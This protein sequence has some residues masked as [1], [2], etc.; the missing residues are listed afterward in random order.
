MA[1]FDRYTNYKD[2]AGVSGV[3]FGADS[4]VLE[5]ELNEMQEIQKHMMHELVKNIVGSGISDLSKLTYADGKVKIEDG[6]ILTCGGYIIKANNLEYST[7]SDII[8]L[9]VWEDIVSYGGI[10]KTEGNFDNKTIV[11]NWIKDDR[12]SNETTKRKVV[13]YRLDNKIPTGKPNISYMAIATVDNGVMTKHIKQVSI[14]K[15]AEV[16]EGKIYGIKIDKYDSNPD[17]RC[18]Y[19]ADAEGMTPAHMNFDTGKFD[20]GSW[21][22]AWFVQ[23]NFPCM[24]K[25]NGAVDYRLNPNNYAQKE[26]GSASDIAN[27][28]YAGNAMSAMPLVWIWQYQSGQYKYIYLASYR[29]NDNFRAYAHQRADGSIA[30]YVYMSMFRGVQVGS[31]TKLRSLSGIK[32]MNSK[33]MANEIAYA[34]ENGSIWNIKSWA[35]RNLIQCLL[36]MMFCGRNSQIALGVGNSTGTSNTTLNTGTLND[37]GQFWGSNA[38]NKQVKAFHQEAVW[39]DIFERLNGMIYDNGLVKVKMT[40]PYNIA[41]S[42]YVTIASNIRNI[43]GRIS[44][45]LMCEYGDIPI[46]LEGSVNTYECDNAWFK[47]GQTSICTV[48]GSCDYTSENGLYCFALSTLATEYGSTIGVGLSCLP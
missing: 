30:N 36:T 22:D 19:L 32:P 35:H 48:G 14:N 8:Y 41:G 13:Q 20:Y 25:A 37:K 5:V 24:M 2:N 33:T 7:T 4:T 12:A 23:Y 31:T 44:G 46:D 18:T 6:C 34:Q 28:S 21:A 38:N 47:T 11:N 17:T 16:G 10:L 40:E 43:T 45:T 39:G 1:N 3:V 26:D 9:L 42:E 27:T 15:S 29:V